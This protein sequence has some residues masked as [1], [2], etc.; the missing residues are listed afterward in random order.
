MMDNETRGNLEDEIQMELEQLKYS[1]LYQKSPKKSIH[2][3]E[4]AS[5]NPNKSED[6]VK[7][8]VALGHTEL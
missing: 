5:Q 4:S 8:S 1:R 2:K 7:S 3:P 6:N